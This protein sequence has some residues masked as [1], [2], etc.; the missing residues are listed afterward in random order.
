MLFWHFRR[1]ETRDS[2]WKNLCMIQRIQ[3]MWMMMTQAQVVH[4]KL[5][6]IHHQT[7]FSNYSQLTEARSIRLSVLVM[8]SPCKVFLLP[9][10]P[11]FPKNSNI[12][13]CSSIIFFPP[14]PFLPFGI[15]ITLPWG[16]YALI[17]SR[18]ADCTLMWFEIS[19]CNIKVL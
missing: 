18:T 3:E 5:D 9:P 7:T 16:R 4:N 10:L 14:S 1:E 15:S 6:F 2:W 13:F 8:W 12:H 19:P 17:Y 11:L